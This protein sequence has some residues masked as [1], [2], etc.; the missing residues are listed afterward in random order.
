MPVIESDC[1][2]LKSY[3][4]SEADRIVVF[5]TRDHGLLRGVAKGAKRLKSK[6]GSSI[7][8]FSESTISYFQKDSVEL[9]SI[10]SADLQRASFDI[11]SR[12]EF[13]QRFA[14]LSE[15]LI[16]FSQPHDPNETLY[17][18]VR[19]CIETASDAEAS[20][21]AIGVYFEA[22]MLRLSGF[23]PDWKTCGNCG[24]A[25]AEETKIGF[26]TDH[27]LA[28]SRC[29]HLPNS[30]DLETSVYATFQATQ[31]TTPAEFSAN[32]NSN[33]R[34]LSELSSLFKR[35]IERAIGRPVPVEMSLEAG[36]VTR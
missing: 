12:P 17:R 13:L 29:L 15:L 33:S 14:Y 26:L 7:E 4:L 27:H 11:A 3:G 34:A 2:I 24:R 21:E 9:V 16:I 20:L 25:M 5:F 22:W 36:S 28:C 18:M 10:Q 35:I 1:I 8:P 30:R 31:K 32:Y 19:S 6:F 23:M